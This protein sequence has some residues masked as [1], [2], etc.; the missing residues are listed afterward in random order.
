MQLLCFNRSII[1]QINS[2]FMLILSSGF[3]GLVFQHTI[4]HLGL[5][6]V[7]F[8]QTPKLDKIIHKQTQNVHLLHTNILR[9]AICVQQAF[10]RDNCQILVCVWGV[11]RSVCVGFYIFLQEGGMRKIFKMIL[12][13]RDFDFRISKN[14]INSPPPNYPRACKMAVSLLHVLYLA[15]MS[16]DLL[17]LELIYVL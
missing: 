8:Q 12:S 2:L 16:L 4:T 5:K 13:V 17:H 10:V 15:V 6:R 11:C 1:M 9:S 14:I 3:S 7:F